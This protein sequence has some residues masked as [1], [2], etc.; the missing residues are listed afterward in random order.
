VWGRGLGFGFDVAAS[1]LIGFDGLIT[2][3]EASGLRIVPGG[4]MEHM[5]ML[6]VGVSLKVSSFVAVGPAIFIRT[7]SLDSK[8]S[9]SRG[10]FSP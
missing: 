4:M 2:W 5:V 7:G 8:F 3:D 6:G 9:S 10:T 1:S